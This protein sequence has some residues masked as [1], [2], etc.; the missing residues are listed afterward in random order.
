M[1]LQGSYAA[2]APQKAAPAGVIL[3]VCFCRGGVSRMQ[4]A[5]WVD[6]LAR[7]KSSIDEAVPLL[8][9]IGDSIELLLIK[10]A[11]WGLA[12]YGLYRFIQAH[13]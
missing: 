4:R 9:G 5:A 13:L 6:I 11:L 10:L 1:G 8:I 2:S 7:F 3:L 12:G